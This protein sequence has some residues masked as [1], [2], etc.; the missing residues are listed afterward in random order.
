MSVNC[1]RSVGSTPP[2]PILPVAMF[3]HRPC[4]SVG[5][6]VWCVQR[7]GDPQRRTLLRPAAWCRYQGGAKEDLQAPEQSDLAA[8]LRKVFFQILSGVGW[9]VV[10]YIVIFLCRSIC[11][12]CQ[13]LNLRVAGRILRRSAAARSCFAVWY[14]SREC[15]LWNCKGSHEAF[16][17]VRNVVSNYLFIEIM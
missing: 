7:R 2:A 4:R 1:L 12:D 15:Q 10:F 13:N 11:D 3:H 6:Q 16:C 8:H 14:N 17:K 5:G 9:L